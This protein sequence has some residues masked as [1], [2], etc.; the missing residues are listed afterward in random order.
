MSRTVVVNSEGVCEGEVRDDVGNG[1]RERVRESA[2]VRRR[3]GGF[4][5]RA[6]V[7]E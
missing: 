4:G 5:F 3:N 6:I 2:M 1:K 7:G